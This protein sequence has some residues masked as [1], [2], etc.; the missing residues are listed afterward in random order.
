MVTF[1]LPTHSKEKS[2]LNHLKDLC[3]GLDALHQ[4]LW[5]RNFREMEKLN[6]CILISHNYTATA[7]ARKGKFYFDKVSV[8]PP[9][10][11]SF[12]MSVALP[13]A[14]LPLR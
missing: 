13:V 5:N 7:L 2:V 14:L 4:K 8:W 1:P 10:L 12:W 3:M 6:I 11:S 9:V